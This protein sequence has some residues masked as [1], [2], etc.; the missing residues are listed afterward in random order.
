MD[1]Y[2][3]GVGANAV[4]VVFLL[5]GPAAA[6]F[7]YMISFAFDSHTTAQTL[8]M[9]L[10][11]VTGLCCMIVSFVLTLIPS[12]QALSLQLNFVFRLFPSFCL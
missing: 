3:T 11:F 7:T 4:I 2:T 8:V 10:N 1:S 9:F 12:T 5:F 6:S